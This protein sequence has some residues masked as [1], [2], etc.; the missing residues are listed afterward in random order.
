[1]I[2]AAASSS[3]VVSLVVLAACP[4]NSPKGNASVLWLAPYMSE[5]QV[6]LV[7]TEPGPY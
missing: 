4:D 6:Q 2:R 3:L 1:M 7:D 5:T